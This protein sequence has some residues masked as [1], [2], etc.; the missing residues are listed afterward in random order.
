MYLLCL[1][2]DRTHQVNGFDSNLTCPIF[3]RSQCCRINYSCVYIVTFGKEK[4]WWWDIFSMSGFKK[5]GDTP[6]IL[7][8]LS[9]IIN[10]FLP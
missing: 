4:L 6:F 5:R 2:F 1:Y 9:H 7:I 8:T 10:P 3:S